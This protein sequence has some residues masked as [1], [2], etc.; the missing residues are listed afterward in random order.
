MI[1]SGLTSSFWPQ[2]WVSSSVPPGGHGGYK[3]RVCF[4][5][6]QQ[7][8]QMHYAW[9]CPT[10]LHPTSARRLF[11]LFHT[12]QKS[13]KLTVWDYLRPWSI[14]FLGYTSLPRR[15]FCLPVSIVLQDHLGKATPAEG[16]VIQGIGLPSGIYRFRRVFF[17][18]C[19]SKPLSYIEY[20]P[21]GS[22]G[23]GVQ[24]SLTPTVISPSGKGKHNKRDNSWGD[25]SFIGLQL[26][27]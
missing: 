20:F 19:N 9:S 17:I 8:K 10:S 26:D 15:L 3:P 4:I 22:W 16:P 1:K 18:S 7:K 25:C 14:L 5:S 21:K 27:T 6:Q 13:V 12:N 23:N 11:H 2:V 24:S